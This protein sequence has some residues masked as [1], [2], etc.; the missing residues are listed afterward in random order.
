MKL[1]EKAQRFLMTQAWAAAVALALL[2]LAGAF[3]IGEIVM[4]YAGY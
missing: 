1:S 2:Y 3:P 4:M